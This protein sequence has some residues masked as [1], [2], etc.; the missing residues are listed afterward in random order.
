MS[1]AA[2]PIPIKN[3]HKCVKLIQNNSKEKYKCW[4]ENIHSS[5]PLF[6]KKVSLE[7]AHHEVDRYN[8][9]GACSTGILKDTYTLKYILD[10]YTKSDIPKR[11]K[12]AIF[13]FDALI[14]VACVL[15][16][17]PSA[18][19]K[20]IFVDKTSAIYFIDRTEGNENYS[21]SFGQWLKTLLPKQWKQLN[22]YPNLWHGNSTQAIFCKT[23]DPKLYIL[24]AGGLELGYVNPYNHSRLLKIVNEQTTL[25]KENIPDK[26]LPAKAAPPPVRLNTSVANGPLGPA[27]DWNERFYFH[28]E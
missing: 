5:Y 26:K 3:F 28:K 25:P 15:Q 23:I 24:N 2:A 10:S 18:L 13:L 6:G 12:D 27:I 20:P 14:N 17:V 1:I 4:F 16:P 22:N 21:L 7:L 8:S 9:F 19:G 11:I